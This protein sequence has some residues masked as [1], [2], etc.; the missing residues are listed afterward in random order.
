ML[1]GL[2]SSCAKD[3]KQTIEVSP[4]SEMP[5]VVSPEQVAKMLLAVEID[6]DVVREVFQAT[7]IS[8][9]LGMDESYRF[10]EILDPN[11]TKICNAAQLTR[12]GT[13]RILG[14]RLK[15]TLATRAS[16]NKKEHIVDLALLEKSDVQIDWPYSENWDQKTTPVVAY[17]PDGIEDAEDYN[18]EYIWAYKQITRPD[19]TTQLDSLYI[20]EEYAIENPVWI[21]NTN[22][23]RYKELP[24]LSMG[25]RVAENGICYPEK[26]LIAQPVPDLVLG[27]TP[28]VW[29]PD[30]KPSRPILPKPTQKKVYTVYLGKFMASRQYDSWISGA[31]EFV[32][33]TGSI[34]D[35]NLTDPDAL[36]SLSPAITKY[37][38]KIK[39]KDIKNKH[40]FEI[41]SV[42]ASNWSENELSAAF[43]IHEDDGGGRRDQKFDIGLKIGSKTY[44]FNFSLFWKKRDDMV[45]NKVYKRDY[46][47][48]SN[49]YN[50]GNWYVDSSGGVY[51]T[52][53]YKIGTTTY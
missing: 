1:T 13:S 53:E 21:V 41:H 15:N 26:E 33:Q 14:D 3:D 51:W 23:I 40:W 18:P 16:L 37:C 24:E 52:M 2:L 22:E 17:V 35:F 39:R 11:N 4:Q 34:N 10:A 36:M 46:I 5:N 30:P 8:V 49:N 48:S 28:I 31:S 25:I 9:D 50:D 43:M 44:G 29:N 45:G 42:M 19:G 12:S 7:Q 27:K 38:I 47:F 32:I 20:N 6:D